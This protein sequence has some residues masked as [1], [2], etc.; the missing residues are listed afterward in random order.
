MAFQDENSKSGA[1]FRAVASPE[2]FRDEAEGQLFSQELAAL[3]L[4]FLATARNDTPLL[5]FVLNKEVYPTF[6]MLLTS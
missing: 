4:R 5:G 2:R 1:S 3:S 6:L